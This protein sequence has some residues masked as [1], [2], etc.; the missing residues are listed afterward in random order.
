MHL[1][2]ERV[3][4]IP[5][6]RQGAREAQGGTGAELQQHNSINTHSE[7]NQR[8]NTQPATQ[9]AKPFPGADFL[10]STRHSA[11]AHCTRQDSR[12]LSLL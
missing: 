10:F 11:S 5:V 12:R 6:H 8:V 9:P 2:L 1:Q 3:W 7:R 4:V